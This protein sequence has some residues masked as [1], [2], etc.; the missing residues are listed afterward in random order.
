MELAHLSQFAY[1][2]YLFMY[3]CMY[4]VVGQPLLNYITLIFVISS[5]IFLFIYRLT[6]I[7]GMGKWN[8][9]EEEN[10]DETDRDSR[11]NITDIYRERADKKDRRERKKLRLRNCDHM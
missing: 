9:R 1:Y 3:V 5:S 6:L 2:F 7:V 11:P 8:E 4:V 10:N